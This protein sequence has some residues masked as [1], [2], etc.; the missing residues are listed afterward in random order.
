MVVKVEAFRPCD[1]PR[2]RLVS[3]THFLRLACL[4]VASSEYQLEDHKYV[5][6]QCHIQII[7]AQNRGFS[8]HL[9]RPCIKERQKKG[10]TQMRCLTKG[11]LVF[12]TFLRNI[13]YNR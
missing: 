8:P 9:I 2:P 11:P 5:L 7:V 4:D 3:Y 13:I 10:G 1:T 6:R 12:I